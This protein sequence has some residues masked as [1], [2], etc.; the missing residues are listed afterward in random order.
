MIKVEMRLLII[1]FLEVYGLANIKSA[2][3]IVLIAEVRTARHKAIKSKVKTAIKKVE[4]AATANEKEAAQ[5]ALT[6]AVM[7]C[8]V[9]GPGEARE[10]DIGIAGGKDEGLIFKKGVI[11]KK[12]PE[13]EILAE[14]FKEID[15][16]V[17]ERKMN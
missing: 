14:L 7:G 5:A 16:I 1:I 9:N 10:A 4:A 6:V 8:V 2:K 12:V 3:K 13:G 17:S 11:I 15:K